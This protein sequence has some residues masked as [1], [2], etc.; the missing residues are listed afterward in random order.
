MR[1]H[2]LD[3]YL[4]RED[5]ELPGGGLRQGGMW[6]YTLCEPCNNLTGRLYVPEYGRWAV[7]A[8]NAL[9]EARVNVNEVDRQT[10]PV[11]G[12]FR[13]PATPGRALARSCGRYSPSCAA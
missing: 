10:A 7:T 9:A 2:S 3:E 5:E 4:R 8:V 12:R 11:P 1:A 13:S 6:G